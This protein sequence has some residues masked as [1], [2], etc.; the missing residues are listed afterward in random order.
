M[1][2]N[3]DTLMAYADGSL[4]PVERGR[5]ELAMLADPAVAAKVRQF[6]DARRMGN[7]I[8]SADAPRPPRPRDGG[9]GSPPPKAKVVQLD[10]RRPTKRQ[11]VPGG[12]PAFPSASHTASSS[13]SPTSA[14]PRWSSPAWLVLSAM[15]MLGAVGGVLAVAGYHSETQFAAV[16][17]N[18][19]LRAHGKLDAA[20]SGQLSGAGQ[21]RG[22]LRIGVSFVSREGQ[23][24]RAFE[25]GAASGL[26]CRA[27]AGW[28]IP[29]LVDGE[30]AAGSYR[31]VG[32]PLPD[33]VLAAIDARAVGPALDG[34]AEQAAAA[35]GW[36]R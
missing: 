9:A 5:V 31:P 23:Y 13:H 12:A 18:G 33:A 27:G 11:A 29:V 6:I 15:L 1:R 7:Y 21:P 3:D 22:S 34:K 17:G 32:S 10:S 2:P 36:S 28:N 25:L 35:R 16:N 14:S 8:G 26:A 24:C 19:L 20:L 4:D 30:G